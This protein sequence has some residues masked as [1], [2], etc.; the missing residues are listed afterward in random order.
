[1][2]PILKSSKNA[3]N[4]EKNYVRLEQKFNGKLLKE[5]M[6]IV[7]MKGDGNCLFRCFAEYIY[8]NQEYHSVIRK[9][10]VDYL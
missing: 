8:G 6:T 9:Y 5:G 2:Q 3:G 7:R 4:V 10:C 1:M